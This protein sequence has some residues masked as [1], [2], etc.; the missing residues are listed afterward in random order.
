MREPLKVGLA[1]ADAVIVLLPADLARRRP[2]LLALFGD[3][4][5]L[6]ARLEPPRRRRAGRRSASPASASP[7]RSSGPEAAGCDLVEFAPFPDHGP[8][9][10][11]R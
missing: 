3:K 7:G 8:M 4:P 1:R 2:D 5:V 6:I 10:R 9:T 11:R